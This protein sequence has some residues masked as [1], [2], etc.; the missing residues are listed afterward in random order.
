VLRLD[1]GA[2]EVRLSAADP[3]RPAPPG[4]APLRAQ[5]LPFVAAQVAR[6]GRSAQGVF[7]IDTGS[8]TAIEFWAPFARHA[9]PDARGAP[10][11][12]IGLG[13]VETTDRGRID[14]LE[15]AGRRITGLTV[16]FADEGRPDG[17]DQAYA[18]V[19]GGPAWSGLALTL[20]F[21]GR[22]MWL[23]QSGGAP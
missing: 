9:F 16:N 4:S 10:G 5:P 13:G 19:I 17:A 14:V 6:S 18:G 15:I 3:D 11:Q 1:Y 22:R 2:S 7:Q 20:D 12:S 21:S 23:E 8:N